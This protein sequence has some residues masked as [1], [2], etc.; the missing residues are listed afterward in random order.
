L[1]CQEGV[2]IARSEATRQS[3]C[4]CQACPEPKWGNSRRRSDG[5]ES[6]GTKP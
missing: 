3:R 2:A 6:R 4:P 5:R 1:R